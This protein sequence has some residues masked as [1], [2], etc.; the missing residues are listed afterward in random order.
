MSTLKCIMLIDDDNIFVALT[1][2]VIAETNFA[3][4]I[5]VFGNGQDALAFLAQITEKDELLP[6][7]IFLDLNMPVLDGWGFLEEFTLM[8]PKIEKKIII[9]IVSSSVSP[10]DINR[11]K[12]INIVSDFIIK[13]VTKDKYKDI[14]KNYLDGKI[15]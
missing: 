5:D 11:A 1:K 4:K 13:P 7:I 15:V 8:K 6:E 9:Y 12:N 2:M 14:I 3:G 10:H